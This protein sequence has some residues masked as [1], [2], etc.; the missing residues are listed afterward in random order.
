[1]LTVREKLPVLE[2]EAPLENELVTLV[3]IDCELEL[4]F[5]N[6]VVIE[7]V[8]EVVSE[9]VRETVMEKEKEEV[10]DTVIEFVGEVVMATD[11]AA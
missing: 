11:A 1:L 9:V 5:V 7:V 3:V 6:D 10:R 8:R 2:V 4:V